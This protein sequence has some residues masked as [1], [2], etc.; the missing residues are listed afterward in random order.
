ME[1]GGSRARV[2]RATCH[3]RDGLGALAGPGDE[4]NCGGRR[5]GAMRGQSVGPLGLGA[6]GGGKVGWGARMP[7]WNSLALICGRQFGHVVAKDFS[8]ERFYLRASLTKASPY[9]WLIRWREV[10]RLIRAFGRGKMR[11]FFLVVVAMRHLL[12]I[13]S[14]TPS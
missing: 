11:F 6:R 12:F 1:M 13:P 10:S 8:V 14:A 7:A 4:G 5:M 3:V 9:F 2:V